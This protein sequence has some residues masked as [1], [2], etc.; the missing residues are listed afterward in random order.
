MS[1]ERERYEAQKRN[2]RILLIALVAIVAIAV[3]IF[4]WNSIRDSGRQTIAVGSKNFTEQL[5]LGN[6]LAEMIEAHTDYEVERKLALG[7][8]L[9]IVEAIRLGGPEGVDLYVDYASTIYINALDR[10][11]SDR[12]IDEIM[13]TLQTDLPEQLGFKPIGALGFDNLYE[14]SVTPEFAAEHNL[15]TVADLVAI[16]D[17][18]ILAPSFEFAVREDGLLGL[19]RAYGLY[20]PE[21]LPME[22]G[23]RYM[24]LASGEVN[25]IVTF[26]TEGMKVVT[27]LVTLEE[28]KGVFMPMHGLIFFNVDSYANHPE[29]VAAVSRLIG[30]V[31]E[32]DMIAMN[33]RVDNDGELP[34]IVAREFLQSRG[35]I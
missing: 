28:E 31:Y 1:V 34:H 14:L 16:Q 4:A 30:Q 35:L 23:L 24:S 15:R 19:E 11:I 18:L 13:I 8:T 12:G 2:K 29:V 9:P 27:E 3:A 20:F 21:V 7:G 5:I 17:Q 25:V 33:Y 26:G 6:L 32:E 22:G 10:P